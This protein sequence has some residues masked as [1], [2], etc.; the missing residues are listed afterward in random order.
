MTNDEFENWKREQLQICDDMYFDGELGSCYEEGSIRMANKTRELWVNEV[1][2]KGELVAFIAMTCPFD[3]YY[4]GRHPSCDSESCVLL[5]NLG[6]TLGKIHTET[7]K[8]RK[9]KIKRI[10]K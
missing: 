8:K 4:E 10:T 2:E 1:K 3:C 6:I 9:V 7:R 5:E